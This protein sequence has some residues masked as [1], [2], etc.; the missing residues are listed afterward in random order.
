MIRKHSQTS[1]DHLPHI[2]SF[3]TAAI[4]LHKIIKKCKD[5]GTKQLDMI[6]RISFVLAENVYELS[7]LATLQ[8]ENF[9]SV[10]Y[11]N[12]DLIGELIGHMRMFRA[13]LMQ[14]DDQ[15]IDTFDQ[16]YRKVLVARCELYI[17]NLHY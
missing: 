8:N 6:Y 17:S 15:V 2:K 9:I 3:C 13:K 7:Y 4:Q 1:A 11:K 14:P 16:G 5:K 10:F 12:H